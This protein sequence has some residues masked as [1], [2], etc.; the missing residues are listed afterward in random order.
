MLSQEALKAIEHMKKSKRLRNIKSLDE[1][2]ERQRNNRII[3][4]PEDCVK[5]EYTVGPVEVEKI[6]LPGSDAESALVYIHGGGFRNGFASNGY[7]IT[8]EIARLTGQTVY[9]M[10]YRLAPEFTY[11]AALDDCTTVWRDMLEKRGIKA[12]K[13][14]FL[15]TSAG[16]TLAL[17]SALWCR[18]HSIPLPSSIIAN[19]PFVA[20]GIIPT[21]YEIEEDVILDY[22]ERENEYF[23][24][25]SDDDPYAYPLLGDYRGF[26]PTALYCAEKEILHQHSLLLE[27]RLKE[28]GVEHT[29]TDDRELWHAFLN[30]PV[31]ENVKYAEEI[32]SF[33][34]KNIKQ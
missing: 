24:T 22:P 19:S 8:T 9:A 11:P 12:E 5:K 33:I 14:A 3:I 10:N 30:S 23:V 2:R 18:D 25:A 13:S 34:L 16:A 21:E 27:R 32:A 7:W 26:P 4:L 1:M 15:G 28:Q 6:S 29:F 20:N 17:S 31:P